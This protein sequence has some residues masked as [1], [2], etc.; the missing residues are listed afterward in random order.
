MTKIKAG[1][2]F[3]VGLGIFSN[4]LHKFSSYTA[5]PFRKYFASILWNI[6]MFMYC[7]L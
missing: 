7:Y 1:I 4:R 3:L 6:K 5:V 2:S